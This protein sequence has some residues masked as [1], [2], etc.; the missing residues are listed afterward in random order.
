MGDVIRPEP[1]M[2]PDEV[3]GQRFCVLTR[4]PNGR[5]ARAAILHVAAFGEEMNL[6][7]R[8][9]ATAARAM[10]DAG[11][12]VLQ[13][14]LLGCGDSS[15]D[16]D[17]ADW[18]SWQADLRRAAAWLRQAHPGVPLW[19]WAERAGAV[20]AGSALGPDL[21]AENLLLWQPMLGGQDIHR[22]WLRQQAATALAGGQGGGPAMA[23]ARQ[24]WAAGETVVI[25][26]YPV[27]PAMA[28]DSADLGLAPPAGQRPGRMV[29]LDVNPRPGAEPAPAQQVLIESWQAA[30]W[31]V[32]H[33]CLEGPAFWQGP[34]S[35]DAPA[36]A[37]RSALA[38][39]GPKA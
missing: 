24:A 6:S 23:A 25:A 8:A 27:S 18:Q 30:G 22:H 13:A 35:W 29:W 17:S 38:L 15:G 33:E 19:L 14:D 36:L 20:L 2:L 39:Q 4:P 3:G 31:A 1:F 12:A 9:V 34:D 26:G 32:E 11:A 5:P 37:T 28:R 10:A 16:L 7:R 21:R